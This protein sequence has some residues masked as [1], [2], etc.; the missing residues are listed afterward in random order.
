MGATGGIYGR[1]YRFQAEQTAGNVSWTTLS[2]DI[3][4]YDA[5]IFSILTVATR[6]ST[7]VSI[8]PD[9]EAIPKYIGRPD[10]IRGY[11]RETYASGDCG[12]SLSDPNACSALQLLGSRVMYAN[13]E[14]R[15]PLIRRFDLGV[16]P[17][18]LPPLDGLVFYDMGVAWSKG[19][20]LRLS[21]PENY[22]FTLE[23]FPL[24]SYGFGL[25]L[26]LFNI[27]LVRW[28][29]AIPLDGVSRKGYW[30]WSL[31]PSF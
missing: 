21:R 23:R 26:N 12:F 8:G 17:I 16:L 25:R 7:N 31:G 20:D 1:R 24:R 3:R 5:L 22:D 14:L 18:S 27:A 15:F 28:D 2:A 30:I 29:Y 4:R 13:A 6:F 9:E 11:D 19:Q 10:F